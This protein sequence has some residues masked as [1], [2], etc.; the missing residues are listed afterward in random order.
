MK[1]IQYIQDILFC[2]FNKIPKYYNNI[3]WNRTCH[4]SD[5]IYPVIFDKN[6]KYINCQVAKQEGLEIKMGETKYGD[7]IL[8]KVVKVWKTKGS[9]WLYDTD[10]YN[11]NL[12][13]SR[14]NKK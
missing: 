13:F 12:K 3:W 9:D 4:M 1:I 7:D 8:Y 11:C 6:K 10:P 5:V 14:I 2:F